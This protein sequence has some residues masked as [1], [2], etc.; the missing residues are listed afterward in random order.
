MYVNEDRPTIFKNLLQSAMTPS[1]KQLKGKKYAFH[2]F[3]LVCCVNGNAQQTYLTSK[4]EQIT[5]IKWKYAFKRER[6]SSYRCSDHYSETSILFLPALLQSVFGPL[7]LLS[8]PAK[9]FPLHPLQVS[10][11][12]EFGNTLTSVCS[13]KA[14][15]GLVPV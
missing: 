5:N 2:F 11:F 10:L 1:L 3:F 6:L 4:C 7:A 15:I 9:T 8:P 14:C 13:H 12:T